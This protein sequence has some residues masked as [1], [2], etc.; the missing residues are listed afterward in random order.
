V[1]AVKSMMTHK[2]DRLRYR[3]EIYPNDR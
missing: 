1:A 3:Y 2:R